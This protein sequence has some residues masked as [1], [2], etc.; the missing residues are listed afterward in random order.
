MRQDQLRACFVAAVTSAF[1]V[2]APLQATA[3]NFVNSDLTW[4]PPKPVPGHTQYNVVLIDTDSAKKT[5]DTVDFDELILY[6]SNPS[7]P[8]QAPLRTILQHQQFSCGW[9]TFRTTLRG[10]FVPPGSFYSLILDRLCAGVPL[11]TVRGAKSV[12]DAIAFWKDYLRPPTPADPKTNTI[13]VQHV[14]RRPVPAATPWIPS[15]YDFVPTPVKDATNNTLF[16]DLSSRSR[17]GDTVTAFSLIVAGP[18]FTR[19]S[20]SFSGVLM[21]RKSRYDCARRTMIVLSQAT[22]NRYDEMV[23]D[24]EEASAERV[25]DES[26]VTAAAIRAA[27]A[28]GKTPSSSLHSIDDAWAFARAQWPQLTGHAWPVCVWKNYPDDVRTRYLSD[29]K[30][31]TSPDFPVAPPPGWANADPEIRDLAAR[32]LRQFPPLPKLD[33]QAAASCGVPQ[34][35]LNIAPFS[36]QA[37]AMERGALSVLASDN[38]DEAKIRAAWDALPWSDQQ[39]F[40]EA[41]MIINSQT[42][43]RKKI[44]VDGVCD[45]LGIASDNAA[46]RVQVEYYLVGRARVEN[47]GF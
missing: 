39:R 28:D 33:P 21:L 17:D 35:F 9:R 31:Q 2:A 23:E 4:E 12:D 14:V 19:A 34:P 46:A 5:G 44:A 40:I 16:L 43:R 18:D 41:T 15:S 29:W 6:P 1:I 7:V 25:S 13:T 42:L 20:S 32:S 30:T 24:D 37:Y 22:F 11:T 38:I 10:A 36:V 27:C 8:S 47:S 26:P 3:H 45:R